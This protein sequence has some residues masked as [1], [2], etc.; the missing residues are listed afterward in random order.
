MKFKSKETWNVIFIFSHDFILFLEEEKPRIVWHEEALFC[1]VEQEM[2]GKSHVISTKSVVYF[3]HAAGVFYSTSAQTRWE[4]HLELVHSLHSYVDFWQLCVDLHCVWDDCTLQKWILQEWT[5]HVAEIRIPR[6]RVLE[7]CFPRDA[8]C[9]TSIFNW[10][11]LL[12]CCN[13]ILGCDDY[14]NCR[15]CCITK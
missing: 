10:S 2:V 4:N 5:E 14:C 13:S 1:N 11:I 7:T 3:V 15:S 6:L 8:V 9:T 12:L